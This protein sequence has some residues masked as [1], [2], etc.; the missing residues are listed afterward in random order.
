MYAEQI[1]ATTAERL[2]YAIEYRH[3]TAAEI[4]K[5]TGI[6][7]GSLSQYISGKFSPKQDRIYVLAKHLRVSPT[8]LMGLDVPMERVNFQP[9]HI[10][11]EVKENISTYETYKHLMSRNDNLSKAFR[12]FANAIVKEFTTEKFD[13]L[14]VKKFHSLSPEHQTMVTGMINGFY[15][16]DIQKQQNAPSGEGESV[17][18][19]QKDTPS[20]QQCLDVQK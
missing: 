18:G 6:S 15:Y 3:T 19:A 2:K 20:L 1:V 14:L 4:S 5:A 10:D 7:R 12:S 9:T 16:E 13:S 11:D 17:P 8:W